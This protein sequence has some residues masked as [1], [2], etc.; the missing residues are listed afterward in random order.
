MKIS[1]DITSVLISMQKEIADDAKES[2]KIF[3]QERNDAFGEQIENLEK[4]AAFEK[5]AAIN[6]MYIAKVD[7]TIGAVPI[8][9]TIASDVLTSSDEDLESAGKIGTAGF[10]LTLGH[11]LFAPGIAAGG[12]GEVRKG[13]RAENERDPNSAVT[14]NVFA[15]TMIHADKGQKIENDAGAKNSDIAATKAEKRAGDLKDKLDG[16]SQQLDSG[17]SGFQAVFEGIRRMSEKI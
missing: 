15:R 14:D 13:L 5:A 10:V 6:D 2:K 4:A 7:H 17:N 11:P 1:G 8:L 12:Y 16:A 9:G 3:R